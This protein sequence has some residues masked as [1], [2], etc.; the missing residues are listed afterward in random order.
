MDILTLLSPDCRAWTL[1]LS[2]H[3]KKQTHHFFCLHLANSNLKVIFGY[4]SS[5]TFFLLYFMSYFFTQFMWW[6]LSF[7][8]YRCH[9]SSKKLDFQKSLTSHETNW[10]LLFLYFSFAGPKTKAESSNSQQ[11]SKKKIKTCSD[12]CEV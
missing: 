10:T 4:T 11:C 3:L 7:I 8:Y 6:I 5:S 12:M 1:E 9:N 2:E